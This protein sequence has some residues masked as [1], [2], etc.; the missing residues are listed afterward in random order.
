M[1]PTPVFPSLLTAPYPQGANTREGP[2][3]RREGSPFAV[4]ISYLVSFFSKS[5]AKSVKGVERGRLRE[6]PII[7][8]LNAF[9]LA[10]PSQVGAAVNIRKTTVLGGVFFDVLQGIA[11]E[12]GL[13]EGCSPYGGVLRFLPPRTC[14]KSIGRMVRDSKS[15]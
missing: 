13:F 5:L 1:S 3:E 9:L 10:H 7:T 14:Q 2:S 15:L 12:S 8:P 11:R 6:S 4:A